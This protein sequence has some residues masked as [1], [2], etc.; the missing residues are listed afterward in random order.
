MVTC[1]SN[2]KW[3]ERE[4]TENIREKRERTGQRP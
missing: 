4:T 2:S 1:E 3:Y